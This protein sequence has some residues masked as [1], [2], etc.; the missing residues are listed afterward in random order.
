MLKMMGLGQ[1]T[2]LEAWTLG[3]SAV[4]LALIVGWI[5]DMTTDRIGFGVL[6]N[7]VICILGLSMSLIFFRH[8]IG[9]ITVV[10]LPQIM[11]IGTLS[12]MVHMFGLIFIRRVLKL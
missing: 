5:L 10:R 12:V 11:A 1:I 2:P 3:L 4:A 9:E 7:A 6:G 8:Y